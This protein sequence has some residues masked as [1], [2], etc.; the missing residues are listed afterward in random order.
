MIGEEGHAFYYATSGLETARAHTAAR[1]IGLAQ[2][3]LDQA[4]AYAKERHQFGQPIGAFQAVQHLCVDMLETVELARG[5]VLH[6]AWSLDAG[7]PDQIAM[8]NR[9]GGVAKYDRR[10]RWWSDHREELTAAL[11]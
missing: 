2:G 5:G 1:A 3:A 7:D 9:T 11:H 4:V 8:V 6:A 10:R